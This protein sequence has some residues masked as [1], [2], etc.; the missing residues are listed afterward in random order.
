LATLWTDAVPALLGELGG[1]NPASFGYAINSTGQ[2]VG[3][4]TTPHGIKAFLWDPATKL[5]TSLVPSGEG[6]PGSAALGINDAGEVVG[7]SDG[8]TSGGASV[9]DATNGLR[10][11]NEVTVLPLGWT[12]WTAYAVNNSGSI[13]GWAWVQEGLGVKKQRAFLLTRKE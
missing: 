11:L 7:Y 12:L 5:M 1:A 10:N 3:S 9:W 8:Y 4:S 6:S 13:A 2:V